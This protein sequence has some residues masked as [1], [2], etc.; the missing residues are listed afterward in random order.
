M[1]RAAYEGELAACARA[2]GLACIPYF[3]L[4][5]GFLTGKYRRDG[6]EV[7]SPRAAG[8]RE[9][10][11]QRARLRRARRARRGRGRR[12]ARGGGGR[13]RVAARP[14]D[15]ARAD[16][17][18]HLPRAAGRAGGVARS[19]SSPPRSSRV[20]ARPA[21]DGR[22]RTWARLASAGHR[23]SRCRNVS[24]CVRRGRAGTARRPAPRSGAPSCAESARL[25]SSAS[26]ASASLSSNSTPRRPG[27]LSGAG[28]AP[29]LCQ[30]FSPTWWW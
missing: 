18:R 2:H 23:A 25:R 19:S 6:A 26:S 3:G 15:R 30:E 27:R 21:A 12:T 10:L 9:S 17:Q 11:L 29:A 13:A 20:W 1:E 22:E 5:R 14:A 24:S 8:V 4:A 16:R 7:D 28:A